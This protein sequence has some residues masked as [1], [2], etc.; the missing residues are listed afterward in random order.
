MW[1]SARRVI[2]GS[3]PAQ[4]RS[5]LCRQDLTRS[6]RSLATDLCQ[7][8]KVLL[9]S[10]ASSARLSNVGEIMRPSSLAVF[11]FTTI[12]ILVGNSTGKP[13]GAKPFRIRRS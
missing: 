6:A 11:R 5:Q 9:S 1:E 12:G 7:T 2:L 13:A 3:G 10:I 4:S 8:R